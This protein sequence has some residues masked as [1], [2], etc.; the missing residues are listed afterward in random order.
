MEQTALV[1]LGHKGRALVVVAPFDTDKEAIDF[2]DTT[3][4]AAYHGYTLTSIYTPDEYKRPAQG[5]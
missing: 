5:G 1:C 4:S 2:F 3:A